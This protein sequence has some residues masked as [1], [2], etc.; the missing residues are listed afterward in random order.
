M[1]GRKPK[2]PFWRHRK[3]LAKYDITLL[4]PETLP[5]SKRF[6]TTQDTRR[7]STRSERLLTSCRQGN[8]ALAKTLCDCRNGRYHCDQPFCPICARRFRRWL[9]GRLLRSVGSSASVTIYTIL[10]QEAPSENITELHPTPFRHLLRKRLQRA[11]L[12]VPVIG[13]FEVVYKAKRKIWVLH[14][15]LVIVGGDKE[16]HERFKKTFDGSDIDRPVM[17]TNLTDPAEQ[18]S[19]VLKFTTYH[20]PFEQQSSGKSPAKSL[21]GRQHATLVEWMSQFEFKDFLLLINVRRRGHEI[22]IK[23]GTS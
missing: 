1:T 17:S 18:L 2:P 21:N 11:G 14:I 3:P 20:R 12:N 4:R 15:N 19:Y 13:G 10:L 22:S 8:K 9:T 23:S 16:A 6:E 5:K 7:E